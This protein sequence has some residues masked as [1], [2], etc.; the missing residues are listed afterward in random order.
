MSNS[1]RNSKIKNE[2]KY[3][4]GV[5]QACTS[6]KDRLHVLKRVGIMCSKQYVGF[7]KLA[8]SS[9]CWVNGQLQSVQIVK[10]LLR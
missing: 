6:M 7:G 9:S 4:N 2:I 10:P 5:I 1:E 8:D 3:I